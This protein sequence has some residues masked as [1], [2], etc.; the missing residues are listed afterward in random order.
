MPHYQSVAVTFG[1]PNSK[2]IPTPLQ[3]RTSADIPGKSRPHI[4][5]MLNN[6]H[7]HPWFMDIRNDIYSIIWW[8]MC[9]V[10]CNE[11]CKAVVECK[12]FESLF[13]VQ[14]YIVFIVCML[15]SIHR[16]PMIYGHL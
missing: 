1:P 9:T 6:I 2:N 10:T 3:G 7:R 13:H 14:P 8:E 15:N 4:V 5:C 16:A 11:S 12:F